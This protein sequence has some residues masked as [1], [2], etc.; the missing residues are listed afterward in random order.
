MEYY[1]PL[2]SRSR[3]IKVN[4]YIFRTADC[5]KGFCNQMRSCLYQYLNGH[6]VRNQITVNQRTQ[7]FIFCF[8]SGWKSY[9]YFFKTNINQS[10][11]KEQLF[12]QIHW[13]DKRLITVTQVYAAPDW[14]LLNDFV[15]PCTV[16]QFHRFKRNIFFKPFFHDNPLLYINYNFY[17]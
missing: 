13:I 15:R 3:I 12:F 14:R 17:K 7:N 5:F 4:N 10:L 6:I 2:K 16:R 9:F 8:G 1:F 11:K